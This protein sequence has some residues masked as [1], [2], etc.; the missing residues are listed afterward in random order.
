MA[1][2]SPGLDQL[3]HAIRAF[4]GLLGLEVL[5]GHTAPECRK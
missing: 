5:E 4:A 3:K 1:A 2:V